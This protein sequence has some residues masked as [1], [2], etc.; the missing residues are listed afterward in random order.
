[1]VHFFLTDKLLHYTFFPHYFTPFVILHLPV[2]FIWKWIQEKKE[3]RV[4]FMVFHHFFYN[5][6]DK[7][8]GNKVKRGLIQ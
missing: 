5:I 1:M 7:L 3:F 4:K 2:T 8:M 6:N